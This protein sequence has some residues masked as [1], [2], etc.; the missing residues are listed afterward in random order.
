[1]S[2]LLNIIWVIC[3]GWLTSLSWLVLGLLW[4][5][6][7]VGLPLGMQCFK[8]AKLTAGPFG[9]TVQSGGGMG[10]L[11]FN[12]L[13]VILT[14]IPMALEHAATGLLLCCTIIGI[15]LGLQHFKI[16]K[17]AFMPFGTTVI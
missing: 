8:F 12:I 17:L 10:S 5:I 1:M 6:T 13:W 3:G 4:S 15:P 7:V 11:L 2:F 14:G 9:K 16:A